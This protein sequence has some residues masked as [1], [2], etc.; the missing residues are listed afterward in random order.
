[1][2]GEPGSVY[3][4]GLV[5]PPGM[6]LPKVVNSAAWMSAEIPAVNGFGTAAAVARFYQGFLAGGELDGARLF[7]AETCREATSV[8]ASGPDVLLGRD[9]DWG[10]GF[11]IEN[12]TFGH[13]GLGGSGGYADPSLALA[14]GYVTNLM[15]GHDRGDA[16]ADAAEACVRRLE[17][18]GILS[19]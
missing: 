17:A 15:A 11:Q 4:A 5:N 14:F 9:V 1:M 3:R 13:G 10:L 2:G 18:D 12:G 6:L 16:V 7:S 8:Q 19:Y